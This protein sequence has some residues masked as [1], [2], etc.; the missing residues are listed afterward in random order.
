MRLEQ[1][2]MGDRVQLPPCHVRVQGMVTVMGLQGTNRSIP[3]TL[4]ALSH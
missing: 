1:L 3:R 2:E 4:G